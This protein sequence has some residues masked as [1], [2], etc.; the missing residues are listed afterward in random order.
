MSPDEELKQLRDEEFQ[1]EAE[2]EMLDLADT[3]LNER[4]Y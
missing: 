4:E 3:S 2:L 1:A